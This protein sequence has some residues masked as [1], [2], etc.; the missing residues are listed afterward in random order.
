MFGYLFKVEVPSGT[1]GIKGAFNVTEDPLMYRLIT[2]LALARITNEDIEL[3]INGK[4]NISYAAEDIQ[5][6]LHYFFNV[7]DWDLAEKK[8]YV[9]TIDDKQLKNSYKLALKGD[10][11][12][13]I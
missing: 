7:K 13:L 1:L 2:S 12:Y 11:D 10:K 4:Y 3:I 9:E 5:E 8:E 6:F